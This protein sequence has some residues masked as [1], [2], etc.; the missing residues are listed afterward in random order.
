MCIY[1]PYL[2]I[3]EPTDASLNGQASSVSHTYNQYTIHQPICE[4]IDVGLWSISAHNRT[5][6]HI[7]S[8]LS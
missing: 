5:Y 6:R 8:F 1:G 3:I 7:W 2:L 4:P